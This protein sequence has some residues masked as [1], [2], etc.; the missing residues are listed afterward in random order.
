MM[1]R[2]FLPA[3]L[4]FAS[5]AWAQSFEVAS[6]R[7]HKTEIRTVGVKLSGPRL[8]AEALSA[9]NLITY[10]YDVKDYQVSGVPS[11]A[12]SK[13]LS[14]DRYDVNA[15]AEGDEPVK[16]D[17]ARAMLQSLLADRFHLQL[18]REKK[19]APVYALVVA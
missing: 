11:W 7:L 1:K 18:H 6:I 16:T 3:A 15:K 10:A 13:N 17:Q 9:D 14:C 2:L 5:V 19:D 12:D 4:A 8:F